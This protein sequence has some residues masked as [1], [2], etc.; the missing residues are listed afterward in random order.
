MDRKYSCLQYIPLSAAIPSGL[1]TEHW[2]GAMMDSGR[3]AEAM[4]K[5][6]DKMSDL[7]AEDQLAK[8]RR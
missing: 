4:L 2:S 5:T 7:S 6:F 1:A 3:Y 8:A